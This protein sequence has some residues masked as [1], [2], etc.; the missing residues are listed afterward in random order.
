[1]K[2]LSYLGINGCPMQSNSFSTTIPSRQGT[3]IQAKYAV[4]KSK[5]AAAVAIPIK[6][7][8]TQTC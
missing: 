4:P 1:M 6:L 2:T 3:K 8:M 7:L 5:N